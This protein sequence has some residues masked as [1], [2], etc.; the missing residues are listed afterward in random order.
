MFNRTS[1]TDVRSQNLQR[2]S[3]GKAATQQPDTD[4]HPLRKTE[5]GP[6]RIIVTGK[7]IGPFSDS[8][9]QAERQRRRSVQAALSGEDADADGVNT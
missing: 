2:T 7:A 9:Y 4:V 1:E 3:K 6:S 5:A 8:K